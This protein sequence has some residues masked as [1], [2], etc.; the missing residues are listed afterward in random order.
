LFV[1]V[2]DWVVKFVKPEGLSYTVEGGTNSDKHYSIASCRKLST[3]ELSVPK[4][5][6]EGKGLC[7]LGLSDLAEKRVQLDSDL[8][9]E[10][11]VTAPAAISLG[12]G[13]VVKSCVPGRNS[14][15]PPIYKRWA[16][17]KWMI[18]KFWG[19]KGE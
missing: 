7:S 9:E 11:F 8:S 10:T 19:T 17:G 1:G 2:V 12:A 14:S 6:G 5:G 4:G 18:L 16:C 13:C 3:A 15:Q